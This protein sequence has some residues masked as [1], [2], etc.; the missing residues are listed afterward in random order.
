MM[1]RGSGRLGSVEVGDA[2]DHFVTGYDWSI[3]TEFRVEDGVLH[4]SISLPTGVEGTIRYNEQ[5]HA[6]NEGTNQF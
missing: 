5:I 4:G 3:P 6:L 2:L 1:E